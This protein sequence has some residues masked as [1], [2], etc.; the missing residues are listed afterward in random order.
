MRAS[1]CWSLC[2]I[3][4]LS[5][6]ASRASAE[7]ATVLEIRYTPVA[8]AQVAIWIEDA[9]GR[10]MATVSLTEA[11]AFRGIG[12]R[13]GAAQLNSGYR[14]P[15]GRREGA[16][17]IW[18]H[19]RASAP[20]ARLF[21]RVIY[22]SRPEGMIMRLHPDHSVDDYYCLAYMVA[23]S[24][25]DA[26][27]AVSCASVFSSDKGRYLT[28]AE[29][30]EGYSEPFELPHRQVDAPAEGVER[31]LSLESLY[32]ARMDAT[33]CNDSD[34]C[35]DHE[36]LKR[37]ASDVRDVMPE[38]DAVTRA[39]A[40]GGVPQSIL[41]RVPSEWPPGRYEVW[42]EA[43]VE[44]DYLDGADDW[45]PVVYPTPTAPE[46]WDPYAAAFGYPYRGQ[47]SIA[48]H[49]PIELGAGATMFA[50]DV[51]AGRSSWDMDA[52][53]YGELEPL[54]DEFAQ[55]AGSGVD[56][57]QR[58][59]RGSRVVVLTRQTEEDEVDADQGTTEGGA[60]QTSSTGDAVVLERTGNGVRGP[61]GTIA[62]LQL[63]RHE[64]PLR[65]HSWMHLRFRAARAEHPLH[66]YD[67]RVASL[68]ITDEREFIERGRPAH[69]ATDSREGSAALMLPVETPQGEWIETTIGDLN[70]DTQ[71]YV[72]VRAVDDL[73]RH[74]PISVAS[75]RT[76]ERRFATVSA[77]FVATAAYGTP[78]ATE[79][80]VLRRLR[81]RQLLAN[82]WGRALVDMY[83]E[84]GPRA[85]RLI[86]PHPE[87]RSWVRGL[88]EPL[89]AIARRLP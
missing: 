15:F 46:G 41:F 40:P 43:N 63:S 59:E 78:L 67:V 20:D 9:A 48:Y 61:V 4:V 32:P 86:A 65:A 12:N 74:G 56:R 52:P 84:F 30:A 5:A 68:P 21:R 14:W 25:R 3:A 38:I 77:C 45:N 88:L 29:H 70:A 28:E 36:D 26:L 1:Y 2:A 54:G 82:V 11:V 89:I 76:A 44:G 79:V 53:D 73:D 51:A 8:R 7:P 33:Y 55:S 6:G 39:T 17:P 16:L 42:I 13:P 22:Q 50:T 80:R 57:L 37:F 49:V 60:P 31:A 66:A 27:D 85:A 58:D 72:G 19:Q 64:D 83:Y 62:E 71:Y 10:F 47:P 24:Q 75:L 81:D 34:K 69:S 87:L 18:A 35:F 23:R